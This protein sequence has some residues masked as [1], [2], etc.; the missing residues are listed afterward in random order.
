MQ[1]QFNRH[2]FSKRKETCFKRKLHCSKIK[3]EYLC[4][5]NDAYD[6][7]IFI[8]C[9]SFIIFYI[10]ARPEMQKCGDDKLERQGPAAKK[11]ITFLAIFTNN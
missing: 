11:K 3:A 10:L 5:E 9:K 7:K 6:R 2:S 8:M 4:F 1:L